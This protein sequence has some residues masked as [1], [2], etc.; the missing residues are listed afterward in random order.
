MGGMFIMKWSGGVLLGGEHSVTA[1][2]RDK[3][4][5]RSDKSFIYLEARGLRSE[6]ESYF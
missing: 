2:M 1:A 4:G 3:L 6:V 5:C